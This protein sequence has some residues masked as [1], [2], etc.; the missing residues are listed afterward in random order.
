MTAPR[1]SRAT[2]PRSPLAGV[3]ITLEL[4]HAL[5]GHDLT[6][7]HHRERLVPRPDAAPQVVGAG[8]GR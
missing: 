3:V 7:E 4:T 6:E 8:Q 2:P 5:A 1:A